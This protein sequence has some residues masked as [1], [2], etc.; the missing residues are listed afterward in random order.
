MIELIISVAVVYI[1]FLLLC[2]LFI[3]IGKLGK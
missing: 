1:V 3:W 2:H